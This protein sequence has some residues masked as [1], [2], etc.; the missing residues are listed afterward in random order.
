MTLPQ[1]SSFDELL[2][3]LTTMGVTNEFHYGE[4]IGADEQAGND[5]DTLGYEVYSHPCT[6]T[7]QRI[8]PERRPRTRHTYPVAEPLTRDRH[9]VAAVRV[10][11]ATPGED[12]ER[13]RSGTW[14]TIRYTGY[15]QYQRELYLIQRDGTIVHYRNG[16]E[17]R[18]A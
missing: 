15:R 2:L 10:M 4:C 1:R 16:Y 7:D 9:I 13:L 14:A 12:E 18:P 11:I 17:R 3:R 8:P 6:L 5:A